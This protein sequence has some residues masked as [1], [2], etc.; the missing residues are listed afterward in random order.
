MPRISVAIR[1]LNALLQIPSSLLLPA[2]CPRMDSTGPRVSHDAP[3]T[4]RFMFAFSSMAQRWFV[5]ARLSSSSDL[6]GSFERKCWGGGRD[7]RV[8]GCQCGCHL[9]LYK[10]RKREEYEKGFDHSPAPSIAWHL[11]SVLRGAQ[12][13]CPKPTRSCQKPD[14]WPS[15]THSGPRCTPRAPGPPQTR[16]E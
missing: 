10:Q 15:R 1:V 16:R 2:T 13:T 3:S 9:V 11:A 7:R 14:H 5:T 6:S 4:K 12:C 8:A